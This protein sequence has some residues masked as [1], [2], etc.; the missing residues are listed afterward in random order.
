MLAKKMMRLRRERHLFQRH[1]KNLR[2]N[3]LNAPIRSYDIAELVDMRLRTLLF[4]EIGQ[5]PA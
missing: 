1:F 4:F 3:I 5:Y 2:L